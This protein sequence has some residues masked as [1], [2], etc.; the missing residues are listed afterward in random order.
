MKTFKVKPKKG[1]LVRDP[2]TREPLK[3][4]GEEKPRDIY[5]LRRVAAGDVEEVKAK[6][7]T[8]KETE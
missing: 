1:L 3:D 5:W 7:A 8:K 2:E 4:T 6:S